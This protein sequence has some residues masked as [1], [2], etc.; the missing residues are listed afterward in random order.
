[1]S[2]N[3]ISADIEAEIAGSKTKVIVNREDT[4]QFAP[5]A[6]VNRKAEFKV[7]DDLSLSLSCIGD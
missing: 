4:G 1:V 3:D 7:M 6:A 2:F 5:L